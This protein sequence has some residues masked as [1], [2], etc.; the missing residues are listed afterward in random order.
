M[1]IYLWRHL[2]GITPPFSQILSGRDCKNINS[3]DNVKSGQKSINSEKVGKGGV[4]YFDL[5]LKG[6]IKIFVASFLIQPP[7]YCWV[8]NDPTT[9]MFENF[10][11]AK[12][13]EVLESSYDFFLCCKVLLRRINFRNGGKSN[14]SQTILRV[15]IGLHCAILKKSRGY[16]EYA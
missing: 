12:I 3:T 11:F 7:P 14:P 5:A 16:R 10:T 8:I 13:K 9:Y 15:R 2:C 1:K 4:K 6:G